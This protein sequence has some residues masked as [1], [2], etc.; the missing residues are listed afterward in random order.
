MNTTLAITRT[1]RNILKQI[2]AK[3]TLQQLNEIPAGYSNNLIWNIAH[4]VVT[5][6]LLVYKLSGLPML[7]SDEMVEKYKKGSKPEHNA[8]QE[9]VDLVLGLLLS[10]I[11]Q[12]EIDIAHNSFTNFVEYPTSTGFVL[13]NVQ[14]AMAFNDFHEGIHLG[15]IMTIRKFI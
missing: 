3:Y 2:L 10:T 8:T 13:K 12:T 14:D 9:E 7:V 1:N 5:Q 15:I 4:V 6:Q 11:D